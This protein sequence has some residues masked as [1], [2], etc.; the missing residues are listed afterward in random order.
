MTT[1]SVGEFPIGVQIPIVLSVWTDN[2]SDHDPHLYTVARDPDGE[3]RGTVEVFWHWPDVDG[4]PCKVGA[5]VLQLAFV[6]TKP[7]T[8]RVGL[9]EEPDCM[10]TDHSFPLVVTGSVPSLVSH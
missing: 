1:F 2:G 7:G 10:E 4:Q 5:R 3:R 9:Y 8:Y 6:A